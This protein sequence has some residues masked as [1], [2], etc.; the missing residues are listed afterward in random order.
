MTAKTFRYSISFGLAG[1]YMPD[2]VN[3][4]YTGTTRRELADMIRDELAQADW[5]KSKLG[6]VKLKRL[7]AHIQKHGSSTAHFSIYHG[8]NAI[9]FNGLTADEASEMEAAQDW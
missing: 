7:W 2:S 4:P 3:G 5:P 9:T 8:A 1:C 6:D